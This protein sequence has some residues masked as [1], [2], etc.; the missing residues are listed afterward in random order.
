VGEVSTV[1]RDSACVKADSAAYIG[2]ITT[3]SSAGIAVSISPISGARNSY[4]TWTRQRDESS[5]STNSASS[6]RAW[7]AVMGSSGDE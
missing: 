6:A 4:A 7:R 2:M 1:D 3:D 5:R